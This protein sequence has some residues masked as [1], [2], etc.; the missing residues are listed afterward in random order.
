MADTEDLVQKIRELL[1]PATPGPWRQGKR[2]DSVVA[3]WSLWPQ[4]DTPESR[5][6]YG[7]ALIGQSIGEP[8]RRLIA[9]AP[10][11]LKRAA[12]EIERLR[13]ELGQ[14][15]GEVETLRTERDGQ[16][17]EAVP[18]CEDCG[19]IGYGNALC[20]RCHSHWP[21]HFTD[22]GCPICGTAAGGER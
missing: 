3:D 22:L 13:D 10:V 2:V 4:M 15:M 18:L 16:Q 5:I 1:A 20:K 11:L 12:L 14:C 19:A 9:A 21:P 6:Y 7:G 17:G 8:N